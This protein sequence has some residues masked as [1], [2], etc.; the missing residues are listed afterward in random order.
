[1]ERPYDEKGIYRK[2]EGIKD[3]WITHIQGRERN[4]EFTSMREDLVLDEQKSEAVAK[5][6]ASFEAGSVA[7]SLFI[8]IKSYTSHKFTQ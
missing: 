7:D 8:R 1:M 6:E 2:H 5:W 3:Y 4:V